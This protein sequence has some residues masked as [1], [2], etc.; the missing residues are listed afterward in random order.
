M[1]KIPAPLVFLGLFLATLCV[2]VHADRDSE[3]EDEFAGVLPRKFSQFIQHFSL[4][5]PTTGTIFVDLL[6]SLLLCITDFSGGNCIS[7]R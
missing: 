5:V 2:S 1:G 7:E 6:H 3:I 4:I